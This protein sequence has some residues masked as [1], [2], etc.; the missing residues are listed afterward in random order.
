MMFKISPED[1]FNRIDN[2]IYGFDEANFDDVE[3]ALP[4]HDV[5]LAIDVFRDWKIY[6]LDCDNEAVL[7][8]K[9]IQSN[10]MNTAL[11]KG[12]FDAII[13]SVYCQIEDYYDKEQNIMNTII[14]NTKGK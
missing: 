6:L 4:A 10:V 9:I 12:E 11:N 2:S 14:K 3:E 1:A 5:T 7:V 13:Y 8:Y